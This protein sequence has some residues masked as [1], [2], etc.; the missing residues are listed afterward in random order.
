M[1][2]LLKKISEDERGAVAVDWVV[3]TAGLVGIGVTLTSTLDAGLQSVAAT[4]FERINEI[5]AS[6]N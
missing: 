3:L 5:V 4:I 1:K 6:V 2:N